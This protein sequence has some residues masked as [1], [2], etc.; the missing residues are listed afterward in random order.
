MEHAFGHNFNLYPAATSASASTYR[1]VL[2]KF[3]PKQVRRLI[4]NGQHLAVTQCFTIYVLSNLI[5]VDARMTFL[6]VASVEWYDEAQ[7]EEAAD[8]E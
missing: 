6:Q 1:A 8:I 7:E 5:R 2:Q 4:D 3:A